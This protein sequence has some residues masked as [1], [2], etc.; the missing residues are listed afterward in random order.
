MQLKSLATKFGK[1]AVTKQLYI[2]ETW[3]RW[4][5]RG[6]Q[7]IL[8]LVVVGLYGHR[9]DTDRRAGRAQAAA[10]VYAVF[11]GGVSCLTCV[12]F[13]VPN[14]F[15]RT[16][17]LFAWD[18]VLFVLWIAVFGAF[19][20]VFLHRAEDAPDYQGTDVGLMKHAV[21][22]DLVNCL[23]WLGTGVYGCFRTFVA[24]RLD[25][26]IG[27]KLDRIEGRVN[28]SVNE[29]INTHVNDRIHEKL[30]GKFGGRF[31]NFRPEFRV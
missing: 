29:Q 4:A 30:D 5:A 1:G 31:D 26:K 23:F 27:A 15:V 28:D 6:L 24:R 14:P 8:A 13:A 22:L 2:Y 16:H 21:W 19:A 12:V 9:V 18:L 17:R 3:L 11:V 10:W 25:Q 20:A 7:F